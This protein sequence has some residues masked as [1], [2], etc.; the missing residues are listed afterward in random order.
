M[1]ILEKRI[2]FRISE[3][4]IYSIRIRLGN[5]GYKFVGYPL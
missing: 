3:I 2:I 5:M 1:K 4:V